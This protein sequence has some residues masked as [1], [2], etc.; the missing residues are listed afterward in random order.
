[1]FP[2]FVH[3]RYPGSWVELFP[4]SVQ[5]IAQREQSLLSHELWGCLMFPILAPL[6]DYFRLFKSYVNSSR[7][8]MV[9]HEI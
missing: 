6:L 4:A 1:M 3:L 2:S 8:P 7:F 9:Y 5:H